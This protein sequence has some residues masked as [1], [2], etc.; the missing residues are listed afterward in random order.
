MSA[1]ADEPLESKDLNLTG[2]SAVV[3]AAATGEW[4]RRSPVTE[5]CYHQIVGQSIAMQEALAVTRRA[6]RS[7]ATVLLLGESG[8]GKELFARAIHN[9]SERRAQPFVAVNC[10][11]LSRELVESELFGY[12]K[13]AFTGAHNLK[14]GKIEKAQG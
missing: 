12:E 6:A 8:T 1:V 13:G 9:W 11:T 7:K 5:E 3:R 10:V 14:L 4:T 2:Q